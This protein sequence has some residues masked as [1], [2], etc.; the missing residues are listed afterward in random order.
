[1][2]LHDHLCHRVQ[3]ALRV[4]LSPTMDD[5]TKVE[6]MMADPLKGVRK[7][8]ERDVR[9]YEDALPSLISYSYFKKFLNSMTCSLSSRN[10]KGALINKRPFL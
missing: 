8:D 3:D 4:N 2:P 6:K 9:Y 10:K 5:Q 7:M 1:M